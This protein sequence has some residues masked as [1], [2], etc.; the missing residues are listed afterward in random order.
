MIPR[1]KINVSGLPFHGL[2]Y[3][4]IYTKIDA[5]ELPVP[6]ATPFNQIL[7]VGHVIPDRTGNQHD[8]DNGYEW[9]DK[10]LLSGP[11]TLEAGQIVHVDDAGIPWIIDI[12]FTGNGIRQY[13]LTASLNRRFG[14]FQDEPAVPIN[15]QFFDSGV[16][17]YNA[18]NGTFGVSGLQGVAIN[19]DYKGESPVLSLR[20]TFT[21]DGTSPRLP[22]M[23]RERKVVE[24]RLLNINGEVNPDTGA[25]LSASYDVQVPVADCCG[26]YADSVEPGEY[27]SFGHQQRVVVESEPN[28]DYDGQATCDYYSAPWLGHAYDS[29]RTETRVDIELPPGGLRQSLLTGTGRDAVRK[30]Y[31]VMGAYYSEDDLKICRVLCEEFDEEAPVQLSYS[32]DYTDVQTGSYI[33]SRDTTCD[34]YDWSFVDELDI[35]QTLTYEIEDRRGYNA[36]IEI[37][38]ATVDSMRVV[39]NVRRTSTI[40]VN[41]STVPQDDGGTDEHFPG[42]IGMKSDSDNT[43]GGTSYGLDSIPPFVES[44]LKLDVTISGV[45]FSVPDSPFFDPFEYPLFRFLTAETGNIL[46]GYDTSQLDGWEVDPPERYYGLAGPSVGASVQGPVGTF[47]VFDPYN[48]STHHDA[49]RELCII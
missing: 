31:A 46:C 34:Y 47:A 30:Q 45:S 16:L 49:T 42:G 6:N 11:T 8:A 22:W 12:T 38:G 41:S 1:R 40:N 33:M 37:N 25:G 21:V 13:T 3:D 5:S 35:I 9:R 15:Y 14:L 23:D 27:T 32:Y 24:V 20:G 10:L 4:G 36:N 19:Q 44:D 2:V 26:G 29:E 18:Y 39:R 7:S 28:P 48:L 43:D 17:D